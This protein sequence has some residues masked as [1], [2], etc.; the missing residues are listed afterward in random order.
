MNDRKYHVAAPPAQIDAKIAPDAPTE[1]LQALLERRDISLRFR[2]FGGGIHQNPDAP[3]PLLRTRRQRP[4]GCAAEK[5]DELAPFHSITSSASASSL[6]GGAMP[7]SLAV[8]RLMAR[9]NF[10][11]CWTGNSPTFSPLRTRPV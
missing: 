11:G 10:V 9:T 1:L 5:R 7:S 4:G 8:F 3:Y 2:L 6:S